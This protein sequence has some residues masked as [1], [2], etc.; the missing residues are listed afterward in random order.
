[1]NWTNGEEKYFFFSTQ[2]E[3]QNA[4][5][6]GDAQTEILSFSLIIL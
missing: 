3:A 2:L 5:S 6:F 1:M 4:L